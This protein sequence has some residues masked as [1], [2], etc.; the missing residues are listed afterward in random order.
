MFF[1]KN[2]GE[3]KI[4]FDK[5]NYDIFGWETNDLNNNYTSFELHNIVKNENLDTKLFNIPEI[6]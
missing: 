3:I 1:D 5:E 6:N 2:K 4:F